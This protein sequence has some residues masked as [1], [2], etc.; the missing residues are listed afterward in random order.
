MACCVEG[1]DGLG[2]WC[3]WVIESFPSGFGEVKRGLVGWIEKKRGKA[4]GDLCG[5]WVKKGVEDP[6]LG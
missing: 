2:S 5:G 4:E 3:E 1:W 6:L